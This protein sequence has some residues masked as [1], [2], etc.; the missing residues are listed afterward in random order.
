MAEEF[1]RVFLSADNTARKNA[2][3]QLNDMM[4]GNFLQGLQLLSQ[5]L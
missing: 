1:L 3:Q 5:G 2:E 4:S